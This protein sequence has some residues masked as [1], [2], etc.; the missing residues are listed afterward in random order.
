M[1][2]R[3]RCPV[4]TGQH[5]LTNAFCPYSSHCLVLCLGRSLSQLPAHSL[6]VWLFMLS[7]CIDFVH[8]HTHIYVCMC[9]YET[10]V[11]ACVVHL[12][13]CCR[14]HFRLSSRWFIYV[15]FH[16]NTHVLTIAVRASVCV[17]ASAIR[18][19]VHTC[20]P[21]RACAMYDMTVY[22]NTKHI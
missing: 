14:M 17:L 10:W 16:T 18:V 5:S 7:Q 1:L 4:L 2:S 15:Q 20:V 13:A 6:S 22:R 8:A 9:V 12:Y 3:S 19:S 11:C 21:M